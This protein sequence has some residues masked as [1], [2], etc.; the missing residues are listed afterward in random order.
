[1][2]DGSRIEGAESVW[3]SMNEKRVETASF[4]RQTENV[5]HVRLR[6]PSLEVLEERSWS[7]LREDFGLVASA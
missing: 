3:R 1:L 5:V 7:F 2:V 4:P 6:S